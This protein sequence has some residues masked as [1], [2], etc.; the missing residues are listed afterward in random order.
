MI[1]QETIL[2][3]LISIFDHF[4]ISYREYHNRTTFACPVH[5]STNPNGASILTNSPYGVGIWKCWT[6]GCHE[7]YNKLPFGLIHGILDTH[8][9]KRHT[10]SDVITWLEK[11]LNKSILDE[12]DYCKI[13][14]QS[15]KLGAHFFDK[16]SSVPTGIE[17]K[18]VLQSLI[19][20]SHYFIR[21]GFAQSI[22][23]KYDVGHCENPQKPMYGRVV[24]PSYDDTGQYMVGCL[25]RSIQPQCILCK[26]F[27]DSQAI[28][29]T[30]PFDEYKASKWINSLGFNTQDNLY[31]LW[32]AKN[33]INE[34]NTAVLVEGTGDVWRLEEAGIPIG[35]G[36]FGA[37]FTDSQARK[38]ESLAIHNLV[39]ATDN[40]EAGQKVRERVRDK[41]GRHYNIFDITPTAKD[42]G[43]SSIEEVQEMFQPLMSKLCKVDFTK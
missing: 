15:I 21:R 17:R 22:L 31:N 40:D 5:E 34:Y 1:K 27:H 4:G 7:D 9:G 33:K 3:N 37:H 28:C 25:A 41:V 43:D 39:I 18:F 11:F 19:F 23:K 14:S 42:L 32:F 12:E 2:D 38:L 24:V 8:L 30:S 35:L 10:A 16:L 29:P 6:R 26:K 36:L 20:P 13:K